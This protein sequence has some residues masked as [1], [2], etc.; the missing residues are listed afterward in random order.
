ME[1]YNKVLDAT[2]VAENANG[3]A[4]EKMTV[5]NESLA[6]AQNRLTASIQQFAQDSNLDQIL[7]LAYDSLSLIV[8]ILNTLINKSGILSPL[9]KALGV[10][11]ATAFVSATIAKIIDTSKYLSA[12]A[13]IMPGVISAFK[14]GGSAATIF[15]GAVKA[16]GGPLTI[17]LSALAAIIA[18]APSV[19]KAFSDMFPNAKQRI[20]NVNNAL[21]E[22]QQEVEDT[23]KS[24]DDI[25]EKIKEINNKDVLTL[26]DENEKKRLEEQ[27]DVLEEILQ[28]KKDIAAEKLSEQKEEYGKQY[29]EKY[30]SG[31][32]DASQQYTYASQTSIYFDT[33]NASVEQLIANLQRL[34]E[35]KASLNKESKNYVEDL[36]ENNNLTQENITALK[37]KA[38]SIAEDISKMQEL[39]LEDTEYYKNAVSRLDEL[40]IYIDPSNWTELKISELIDTSGLTGKLEKAS[41]EAKNALTKA[42]DDTSIEVQKKAVDASKDLADTIQTSAEQIASKI[43]NDE[44]LKA[45]FA[46]AFNIDKNELEGNTDSI[47]A[48][49]K[50]KLTEAYGIAASSANEAENS[51]RNA[52]GEIKTAAEIADEYGQRQQNLATKTDALANAYNNMISKGKITKSQMT[53]LIKQY[54]DLTKEIEVQN[55]AIKIS[56]QTLQDKYSATIQE[57]EAFYTAQINETN[58]LIEET[59]NRIT[60]YQT[61]ISSLKDLATAR[62]ETFEVDGEQVYQWGSTGDLRS[63]LKRSTILNEQQYKKDNEQLETLIDNLDNY[64]KLL[65]SL[66]GQ[67]LEYT[68]SSTGGSTSQKSKEEKEFEDSVKDKIK[69]LGSIVE[70]YAKQTNW[71]DDSVIADFKGRY[72][73]VLDE[74]LNDPKSRKIVAESLGLDISKMSAEQ[75]IDSITK[76]LEEQ[77]G[78]I[79]EKQQELTKKYIENKEKEVKAIK[80]AEKAEKERYDNAIK[81]IEELEDLTTDMIEQS[82]DLID[83]AGSFVFDILGKI[84]DRYDKQTDNLDKISDKLDEQKD[85]FEDKIDKQKELLKLQKQEADNADELADKNKAIADI[86]A[87]LLELQYDNSA[88]A[89]AK[90]LKLLDERAQK[91][92]D[93]ADWQKENDYDAKIDALDKEKSEYEK[94]IE[95]EKKALEAQKKTIE[96]SQKSFENTFKT[97]QNGFNGIIKILNS[98]P[99]KNILTKAL[100][101]YGGEDFKNALYSYNKIFGDGND[102][103]VKN[104]LENAEKAK[105]EFN[106]QPGQWI[107]DF[108]NWLTGKSNT[109]QN[110]I[111]T[112]DQTS[113]AMST[114]KDQLEAGAIDAKEA[115][116][117]VVDVNKLKE[118]LGN[119]KNVY[120]DFTSFV[121][122]NADAI[123]QNMKVIGENFAKFGSSLY[124]KLGELAGKGLKLVSENSGQLGAIF[125]NAA[126]T[127]GSLVGKAATKLGISGIGSA[128]TTA[129]AGTATTAAAGTAGAG[130][131][132]A[133]GVA[134]AGGSLASVA[135]AAL[136]VAGAVAL[137]AAAINSFARGW[138]DQKKIMESDDPTSKKVLKTIG[139]A[140]WHGSVFGM[141]SDAAKTIGGLFGKHHSGADYVKK[142]NPELDRMLGLGDDETVSILKVGEAVVPT[143]ANNASVNSNSNSYTGSSFGNAIDSAVKS[144]RASSKSSY[145]SGDSSINIS[146]PINIQ[147]DA[148]ASTVKALQKETNNIVN[149]VLKTINNQTK[150]GGYKNI[151]AATV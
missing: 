11:L 100:I 115:F 88:E 140:M 118:T 83:K 103:T 6:A 92:K 75:A 99:V 2:E 28:Y 37:Q 8:D 136:P 15:G 132:G 22:S 17:I 48:V 60:A 41:V 3:V 123:G 112:L 95:V 53:A 21:E 124:S 65:D 7:A 43:A 78:T 26:A 20:E 126:G 111:D 117:K 137:G 128:A 9:I 45:M 56:V 68:G 19:V 72:Q 150:I 122:K 34:T 147:G 138:Q 64:Q 113:D 133:G 131:A 5:Y 107:G 102:E 24:L 120:G 121:E 110:I 67:H 18:I 141:V 86:D 143:W 70:L 130:L 23:K 96:D 32:I 108:K 10:A 55:G 39:G 27:R 50:E 145:S 134:A 101:S 54:P 30:S 58:T 104:I 73:K 62:G 91:E 36:E 74:I 89:Q 69:N 59:K 142:Q 149:K 42:A 44:D 105:S 63:N 12:I 40:K 93:L 13:S 4:A 16:A 14:A 116:G 82:I 49:I 29:A 109:Q 76:L 1:D 66:R 80:D 52:N 94:T 119:A 106:F 33:E 125:Q 51:I 139:N 148:D 57:E 97:I 47:I 46:Q 146:M 85:A 61:E 77:Y 129:A 144:A 81:A 151:K 25:N 71:F 35:K 87:Q 38:V 79:D 90:R 31:E 98:T 135:S 84:S 127:I 114:L